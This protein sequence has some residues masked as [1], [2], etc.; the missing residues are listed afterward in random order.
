MKK[1]TLLLLFF[2]SITV[3][4]QEKK[5]YD[6]GILTDFNLPEVTPLL[7][8]LKNEITAV[9]GEDA[10]IRF[11]EEHLLSNELNLVKAEANYQ[12][13]VTSEVDIILAFGLINNTI[14]T[15]QSTFFPNQQYSSGRSMKTLLLLTK[16]I[17]PLEF[18]I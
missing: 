10:L 18:L 3:L 8:E 9:V 17:Q 1:I 7:E 2:V 6:I 12:S 11:S 4:S 14:I 5:T 13:L 15:K 16:K